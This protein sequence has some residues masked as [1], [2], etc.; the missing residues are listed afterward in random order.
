MKKTSDKS[1]E[2]NILQNTWQMFLE[3]VKEV[4]IHE[5]QNLHGQ[6]EHRE[7]Q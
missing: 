7:S 6:E 5:N 2:S 1:P 4:K 3:T